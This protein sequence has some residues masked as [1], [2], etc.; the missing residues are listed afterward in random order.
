VYVYVVVCACIIWSLDLSRMCEGL[1]GRCGA[2]YEKRYGVALV[3]RID[4]IVGFFCKR[5]L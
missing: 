3:S 4:K 1:G 5:A 2:E